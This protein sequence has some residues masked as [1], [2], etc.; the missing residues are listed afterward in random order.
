MIAD[1]ILLGLHHTEICIFELACTKTLV[2]ENASFRRLEFLN[3]C[4]Q[5]TKSWFDVFFSFPPATYI[6]FPATVLIQMAQSVIVLY[7]LSMF[8]DPDWDIRT[9]R[10]TANLSLILEKIIQTSYRVKEAAE[11]DVSGSELDDI[12]TRCARRFTVMKTCYD[13]RISTEANAPEDCIEESVP[14]SQIFWEEA[15]LRDPESWDFNFDS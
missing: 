2:F 10:E 1:V 14:A 7:R 11:L 6:G 3:A 15:W 9:V 5:A 13:L 12:Y 8:E 4:L